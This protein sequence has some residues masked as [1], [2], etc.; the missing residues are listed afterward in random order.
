M[1]KKYFMLSIAGVFS[2]L[3]T[4][5]AQIPAAYRGPG[6]A[7]EVGLTTIVEYDRNRTL[8]AKFSFRSS[9]NRQWDKAFES[10]VREKGMVTIR[11]YPVDTKNNYPVEIRL[12]GPGSFDTTPKLEIADLR[13]PGGFDERPVYAGP[14]ISNFNASIQ[15]SGNGENPS[16]YLRYS[17][18]ETM[19]NGVTQNYAR[20]EGFTVGG[21]ATLSPDAGKSGIGVNASY[22]QTTTVGGSVSTRQM[23]VERGNE[24]AAGNKWT[25]TTWADNAGHN[26]DKPTDIWQN[27]T[28]LVVSSIPDVAKKFTPAVGQFWRVP[29]GAS[30]EF[31]V[32]IKPTYVIV[33]AEERWVFGVYLGPASG[34]TDG[35][36]ITEVSLSEK[37]VL[38]KR[39]PSVS[40]LN[41]FRFRYGNS[42]KCWTEEYE[43]SGRPSLKLQ[44]CSS[45]IATQYFMQNSDF[46]M[47]SMT[48]IARGTT[49]WMMVNNAPMRL[50]R[51]NVECATYDG[52][53]CL[54]STDVSA[55]DLQK[56]RPFGCGAPG[57][58]DPGHWCAKALSILENA[59]RWAPSILAGPGQASVDWLEWRW[60]GVV[61]ALRL[62]NNQVQCASY[63]GISCLWGQ[64]ISDLDLTKIKPLTC[65]EDDRRILRTDSYS[66]PGHWCSKALSDFEMAMR[67]STIPNSD[68][69]DKD[70]TSWIELQGK[71]GIGVVA[72]RLNDGQAQCASYDG[73][74]CLWGYAISDLD[75]TKIKPVTCGEQYRRIWGTDGY[76]HPNHWC[77]KK[78]PELKE[79]ASNPLDKSGWFRDSKIFPSAFLRIHEG[80]VACYSKDGV[81]CSMSLPSNAVAADLLVC[82]KDYKS[83][84]GITGYDKAEHWCA[85]VAAKYLPVSI[86]GESGDLYS[87]FYFTD[88]GSIKTLNKNY[89]IDVIGNVP[90]V[91]D[92]TKSDI[93]SGLWQYLVF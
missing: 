85:K 35:A 47:E 42:G 20:T 57:Y 32:L 68:E 34:V 78:L 45:Q 14:W 11:Q 51:G 16:S 6:S 40:G 17:Y 39:H 26:I 58:D 8:Y 77:A 56:V 29:K 69:P 53:S 1:Y 46:S 67:A 62:N 75:L 55:L 19:N 15:Y 83:K 66:N 9:Y 27:G 74:N 12:D 91:R 36:K 72:L 88:N 79:I 50:Y 21:S 37:F 25:Y 2:W 84:H 28:D 71:S 44:D 89:F 31:N 64:K 43:N 59:P 3:N 92:L 23:K 30:Q 41:T 61:V 38:D 70:N 54:W 52:S 60:S 90:V 82:G 80:N 87:K 73:I 81:N 13:G 86:T 18:P 93:R 33:F 5:S 76:G 24:G 10:I 22:S 63:D 49:D 7:D 48:A 65:G 4:V